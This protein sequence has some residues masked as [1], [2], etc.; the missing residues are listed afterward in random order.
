MA[1]SV[2]MATERASRSAS[3]PV[4][5]SGRT[6]VAMTA[7]STPAAKSRSPSTW[8]Q[9]AADPRHLV[10]TGDLLDVARHGARER[11]SHGVGDDVVGDD[12][13]GEALVEARL[14]RRPEHRHHRHERD[15]DHQ[16]RGGGR[17]A[18]RVAAR[19]LLG[20]EADRPEDPAVDPAEP[21]E[22]GAPE[23]RAEQG[24][25]DEDPERAAAEDVGRLRAHLVAGRRPSPRCRRRGA[26][27]PTV[28][29]HFRPLSAR[30]T[31]SRIAATGGTL[32][33]RRAGR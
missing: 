19:V 31:S 20:H 26:P 14:R 11:L 8:M 4:T 16:R 7:G 24:R 17:R 9:R 12:V 2:E 23:H 33:A 30:A 29:R 22:D 10:D 6:T 28:T 3:E 21:R 1:S 27:R 18:P 32:P 15:A 25:S 5:T 13:L